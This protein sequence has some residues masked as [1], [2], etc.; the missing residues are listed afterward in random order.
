V[1]THPRVGIRLEGEGGF[2]HIP[3]LARPIEVDTADLD[4]ADATT[5]RALLSAAAFFERPAEAAAPARG[6]ADQRTWTLT[7]TADGRSHTIRLT[8]PIED[9]ALRELVGRLR[10]WH[11]S[12]PGQPG[13]G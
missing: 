6:A 7:A 9:P 10:A 11:R 3:G 12:S 8:D 5:L 4:P 1:V 2:A 13:A